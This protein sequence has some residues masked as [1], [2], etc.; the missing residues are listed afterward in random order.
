M[1]IQNRNSI[2]RRFNEGVDQYSNIKVNVYDIDKF[3]FDETNGEY[4]TFYYREG[5]AIILKKDGTGCIV[6]YEAVGESFDSV[7]DEI[8]IAVNKIDKNSYKKNSVFIVPSHDLKVTVAEIMDSAPVKSMT[9]DE[10]FTK[11]NY[12][13]RCENNFSEVEEYLTE[14]VREPF[15]RKRVNRGK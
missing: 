3:V 9:V 15:N 7:N 10:F 5:A 4:I 14:S 6:D 11:R 1:A 12:N 13:S 8:T 2:R